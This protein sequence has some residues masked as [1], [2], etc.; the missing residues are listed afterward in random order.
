MV[1]TFRILAGVITGALIA[2]SF[3]VVVD[4]AYTIYAGSTVNDA[5]KLTIAIAFV[6]MFA[7]YVLCYGWARR[8]PARQ[9]AA[10]KTITIAAGASG[11][12]LLALAEYF[13]LTFRLQF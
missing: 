9:G 5:Y 11:L 3:L 2:S 4:W 13:V 10:L 6:L 7:L 8:L 1:T 12:G